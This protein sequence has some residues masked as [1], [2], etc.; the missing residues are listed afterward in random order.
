MRRPESAIEAFAALHA[1][2]ADRVGFKVLTV[3]RINWDALRS[4][5][6]YSSEPSYPV[7]AV[8][9]HVASAWSRAVHRDRTFFL[10]QQV[11]EV[12]ETFPDSAGIEATG[13][14]S[15]LALP[16]LDGADVLG[17][18]NLWHVDG[19]YDRRKG[20]VAAPFANAIAS[21]CAQRSPP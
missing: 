18:V 2:L 14:G 11:A 6:L 9:Q 20:K 10:A 4:V 5:R 15:I 8:K 3:L 13:C 1:V 16:I 21:V 17:T 19:F 7:G 12:R